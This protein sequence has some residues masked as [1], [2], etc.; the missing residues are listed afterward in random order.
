MPI[1]IGVVLD[2]VRGDEDGRC[3]ISDGGT[4]VGPVE[5]GDFRKTVAAVRL[6]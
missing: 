6:E 5:V 4:R 3:T 2:C 1:A